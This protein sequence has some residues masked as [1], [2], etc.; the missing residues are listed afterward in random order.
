VEDRDTAAVVEGEKE[1]AAGFVENWTLSLDGAGDVPWRL[2]Q[3]TSEI[4]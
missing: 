2:A 4:D 1:R 3:S